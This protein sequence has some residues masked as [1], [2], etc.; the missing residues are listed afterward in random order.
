MADLLEVYRSAVRARLLDE[1]L[2]IHARAG[3]IGYHPDAARAELVVVAATLALDREDWIFPTPRDHAAALARGVSLERYVD[4]AVGNADDALGGH[5][6]PGMFA[7][8][9]LRIASPSVQVSQHLTHA[10]GLAWAAR[11][12]GAKEVVLALFDETAADAGDFH[13]AVN[14]AGVTRAPIVFLS[15]TDGDEA[16]APDVEV[17][18][19][20]V[21][22]GVRDD[23]CAGDPAAVLEHVGEAARRARAGEGP[24]LLEVRLRK[25]PDP[26]EA[27]RAA[28]LHE[29]AFTEEADFAFRR[30]LLL[31]L[32]RAT[33][34]AF[35]KPAPRLESL[36]EHLYAPSAEG[37]LPVHVEAQRA[38]LRAA[39]REDPR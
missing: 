2:A 11:L 7:S 35:A 24:T 9:A 19:K 34:A 30:E 17:R 5:G 28:L 37:A 33:S 3:H 18:E 16:P 6:S 39:Y 13:S 14:F 38:S 23:E 20:A 4:H 36:F 26:L 1:R 32:E 15:K 25:E 22:Y 27:L 10:T 31:E 8:R 21:A 12:R 29:G